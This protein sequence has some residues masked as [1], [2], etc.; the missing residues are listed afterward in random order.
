M[1]DLKAKAVRGILWSF[2][3]KAGYQLVQFVIGVVLA[4]ILLPEDFGVVAILAVL[5]AILRIVVDCGLGASLIQREDIEFID[6]C[7]MFWFNVSVSITLAALLSLSAASIA[8]FFEQPLYEDMIPV[9][10]LILVFGAIGNIQVNVLTRKIDFQRQAVVNV[11][12]VLVSGGVGVWMAINNYGVW[13]LVGQ[14]TLNAAVSMVLL[15][16]LVD[17]RPKLLFSYSSLRRMFPFGIH[18]FI[19]S[20]IDAFFNNIYVLLIGKVYSPLELGLFSKAKNIQEIPVGNI[21]NI[22]GR[23]AFP[24][25]SRLQNDLNKFEAAL[26]SSVKVLAFFSFPVMFGLATVGEPFIELL[27]TEKWLPAVPYLQLL[28]IAGVLMPIH[29]VNL[30]VLKALG[31]SELFLKIEIIK[32]LLIV[33]NILLTYSYGIEAMLAGGILVSFL[34]FYA[35]TFY[36]G[37]LVNFGFF[38]QLLAVTPAFLISTAMS[39][40]VYYSP[41]FTDSLF[42]ILLVKVF[43]GTFF[44]LVLSWIFNRDPLEQIM[45]LVLKRKI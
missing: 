42:V 6:E 5:I 9:I 37:R 16:I 44:Y 29:A 43:I 21:Y 13:S 36:S 7:T 22:L 34:G 45:H 30:S 41:E 17:W 31:K 14:A 24:V 20:L 12:S 26:K 27:L 1:Q 19:S 4:R 40:L 3:E 25:F 18:L 2:T 32:K 28:C 11:F 33:V 15:W 8:T 35:N 10:S 38:D 23:V 39:F